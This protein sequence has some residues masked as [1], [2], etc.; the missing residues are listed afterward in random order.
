[1]T[2]IGA[3]FVG[4]S[5]VTFSTPAAAQYAMATGND[6]L[7]VC[8]STDS[9]GPVACANWISGVAA[10]INA[11]Q[12]LGRS[13]VCFP[14]GSNVGQYRDIIVDAL[15]RNPASR[16]LHAGPLALGYLA[17]AFPCTTSR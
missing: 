3:F 11:A 4:L 5:L 6:V 8:D 10:G 17:R 13:V 16:H 7:S 15:R 2:R 14:P 1:M 9:Y 12:A